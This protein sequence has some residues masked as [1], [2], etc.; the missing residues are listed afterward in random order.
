MFSGN[1]DFINQGPERIIIQLLK[2]YTANLIELD[3]YKK[4]D[5]IREWQDDY[6]Y[7]MKNKEINK[8]E[9]GIIGDKIIDK[10]L[11]LINKILFEEKK[12]ILSRMKSIQTEVELVRILLMGLDNKS[13]RLIRMRYFNNMPVSEVCEKL[14]MARSTFYRRH[15]KIMKHFVDHYNRIF[16]D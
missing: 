9:V 8:D 2:R 10:R 11:S 15:A 1:A 16:N 12:Y 5:T 6:H 4:N 3:R 7:Y 13:E 14:Y